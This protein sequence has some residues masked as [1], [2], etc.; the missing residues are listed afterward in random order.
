MHANAHAQVSSFDAHIVVLAPDHVRC[1]RVS[2][3]WHGEL[4]PVMGSCNSNSDSTRWAGLRH[5]KPGQQQKVCPSCSDNIVQSGDKKN[6][7]ISFGG[8]SSSNLNFVP[9]VLCQFQKHHFRRQSNPKNKKIS[10]EN[11]WRTKTVYI[12]VE[13]CKKIVCRTDFR[14]E[15]NYKHQTTSK[16]YLRTRAL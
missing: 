6:R 5:S 2:M 8:G 9:D 12:A 14:W 7:L 15:K 1:D 3:L 11:P 13:S 4:F 10:K 16:K